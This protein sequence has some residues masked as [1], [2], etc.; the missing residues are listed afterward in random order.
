MATR[1]FLV[2]ILVKVVKGLDD[3]LL[4]TDAANKR[5][6]DNNIGG[7]GTSPLP[8]WDATGT[9]VCIPMS[10]G[11]LPFWDSSGTQTNVPLGC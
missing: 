2:D 9:Q 3:P 4:P 10:N 8:F 6:V 1:Q 7:G 11:A 5:Y